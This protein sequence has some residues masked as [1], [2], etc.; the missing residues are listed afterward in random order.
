MSNFSDLNFK[1][2]INKERKIL[3]E[4]FNIK[5]EK[6]LEKEAL[7]VNTFNPHLFSDLT[8]V[9]LN[10]NSKQSKQKDNMKDFL[11]K[12]NSKEQGILYQEIAEEHGFQSLFY[13][14]EHRADEYKHLY[15][16]KNTISGTSSHLSYYNNILDNPCYSDFVKALKGEYE[17]EEPYCLKGEDRNYIVTINNGRVII[18]CQQYELDWLIDKINQ[19]FRVKGFEYI[20]IDGVGITKEE[21][22]NLLEYLQDYE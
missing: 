5:K 1:N 12:Y 4:I 3:N 22:K 11:V 21:L 14:K 16:S 17:W 18:G 9:E 20:E 8:S 15:F 2:S 19:L 7:G 13:T 10:S 6:Q